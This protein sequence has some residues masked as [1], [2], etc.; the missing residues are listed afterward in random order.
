MSVMAGSPNMPT[1]V[2]RPIRLG[3]NLE[4]WFQDSHAC[5]PSSHFWRVCK[6]QAQGIM[7]VSAIGSAR[8][9]G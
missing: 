7:D 3:E 4:Q 5:A 6:H 2:L 1:R 8:Y 9:C